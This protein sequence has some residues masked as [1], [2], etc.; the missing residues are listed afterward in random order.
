MASVMGDPVS[1]TQFREK[2]GPYFTAAVLNH[3]PLVIQRGSNDR[4]LLIGV[5]ELSELL[6]PH[7]FSPEV[8]RGEGSV[9]IWL[10][11]FEIYGEGARYA[12][13]REDLLNEVRVY[14]GEYLE[15]FERYRRAPNRAAHLPYIFKAY[16]ADLNDELEEAIFPPG[17]PPEFQPASLFQGAAAGS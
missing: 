1:I 16:L 5:D 13:A 7:R 10:P 8:L 6:G 3:Q 17:P 11:E 12:E 9:S 4:G 15:A 14:I 2:A